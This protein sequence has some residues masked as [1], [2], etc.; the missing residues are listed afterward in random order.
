M[1]IKNRKLI[2]SVFFG[3]YILSLFFR[4]YHL[5]STEVYPDEI[6]WMVKA[7]E[8][9]YALTSF[10]LKYFENAWW[11]SKT[12]TY[13]ISWPLVTM[14]GPFHVFLSGVGKYSLHLLSD[15]VAS[16]LPVAIIGAFLGPVIFYYGITFIGFFPAI[17][18]G[19]AYTINPI[20]ISLDR[21]ILNDSFLALFSFLAIASFIKLKNKNKFS[22]LPGLW[23]ALSFLSKP[24]GILVAIAWLYLSITD[25]VQGKTS[26]RLIFLNS[27]SFF[28][29]VTILWPK[30]WIT[31]IF[32]IPS[33]L[34]NQSILVNR[35][36]PIHNFY[37]GKAVDSPHWSYYIFQFLFRTPEILVLGFVVGIV[38]VLVS[39]KYRNK[40]HT[41]AVGAIVTYLLVALFILST[42]S[43]KGGVRYMLF[44]YPWIY[45]FVAKVLFD[46][47][48]RSFPFPR[49]ALIAFTIA[50]LLSP[51]LYFPQLYLYYNQFVKGPDNAKK[52]DMVGLCFGAKESLEFL[53]RKGLEGP[54]SILG[55]SDTGSYH[56]SRQ[57]TKYIYSTR[58][59]V[60]ESAYTQQFP[61]DSK[62]L[63]LQRLTPKYIVYE[64]G[65]VT[66][67]IYLNP[68][69]G[70]PEVLPAQK[71]K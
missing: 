35:G 59:I 63:F 46:L 55:C 10:N 53:D 22:P 65:F 61:T 3:I 39:K 64:K 29:W 25:K 48:K 6:T 13:A 23:L 9:F 47:F 42:S 71:V 17:I 5:S 16:R 60:L 43:V 70:Q 19:L 67:R 69:Y 7:K 41:P 26:W 50:S 37:F 62:V 57:L 51:F 49:F 36:D 28:F 20:V 40:I 15:I 30:S 34:I 33:Y 38:L 8:T 27:T 24:H 44:V 45:I 11:D 18:A 2:L 21:W 68:T 32:A 52:Y 58:W 56:S 4:L 54:A 31:P 14:V 66:A 12:D 1:A